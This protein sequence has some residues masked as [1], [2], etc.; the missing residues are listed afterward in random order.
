MELKRKA[1]IGGGQKFMDTTSGFLSSGWT[2]HWHSP[3]G[4][5]RCLGQKPAIC[6]RLQ[7]QCSRFDGQQRD[8]R[9]GNPN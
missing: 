4:T 1:D 2:T 3:F 7:P 8:K 6:A 5:P 9:S